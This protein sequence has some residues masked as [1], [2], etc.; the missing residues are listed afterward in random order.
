MISIRS[1]AVAF[2]MTAFMLSGVTTA[3]ELAGP[4]NSAVYVQVVKNRELSGQIVELTELKVK[5]SF[6]EVPIPIDKID[7]IKMHADANDNAVIAF[8]NGDLV[9]GKIMLDK[10]QLK[11]EWGT[12][13][14]LT[15]KI[16]T[17]TT[18]KSAKFFSDT[19]GGRQSWRFSKTP[20][21]SGR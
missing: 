3:Q 12:A 2:A 5:T 6:G 9:T 21:S 18:S 13:H 1:L 17:V 7:G 11:T 8:K 20:A 14:I 4:N 19:T 15:E 10:L 16:E